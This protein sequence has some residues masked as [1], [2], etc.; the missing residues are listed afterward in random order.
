[1][2]VAESSKQK[3][4][5]EK[6]QGL[7][8]LL[9]PLE[10]ATH[11]RNQSTSPPQVSYL[12]S[13]RREVIKKIVTWADSHL[14]NSHICWL[15]GSKGS[16]KSSIAQE[17][18]ESFEKKKRLAGSYFWSQHSAEDRR[19][20]TQLSGTLAFQLASSV[21]KTAPL[22]EAALVEEPGL[23]DPF[24]SIPTQLQ[25]LVY[26]PIAKTAKPGFTTMALKG[27]HLLVLDGIDECQDKERLLDFLD[28]AGK[29][30]TDNPTVPLRILITG[31]IDSHFALRAD[32]N[33][34]HRIDLAQYT[35]K[36]DVG[37]YIQA[38][39]TKHYEAAKQTG[40][41]PTN[42]PS[43]ADIRTLDDIAN[44]SFPTASALIKF[45]LRHGSENSTAI[46]PLPLTDARLDAFY[47]EIFVQAQELPHSANIISAIALLKTPVSVS[48]LAKLLGTYNY[49]VMDVLSRISGLVDV[50]GTD[51]LP[52][53]FSLPGVRD[54]LLDET[55][56]Q[57][58]HVDLAV[59]RSSAFSSLDTAIAYYD[60]L[61]EDKWMMP[62]LPDH[63]Q[64][65]IVQWPQHLDLIMESD[66]S[67]DIGGFESRWAVILSRIQFLPQFS[68]V[69]AILAL[70]KEPIPI[71]NLLAILQSEMSDISLILYGLTPIVRRGSRTSTALELS[72]R[73]S[74]RHKAVAEFLLD[75]AR[76]HPHGLSIAPSEFTFLS[77]RYLDIVFGLPISFMNDKS[78][79]P[80][81]PIFLALAVEQ[82]P[83][84]DL[85]SLDE[86]YNPVKAQQVAQVDSMQGW[87]DALTIILEEDEVDLFALNVE[88]AAQ[89]IVAKIPS[90]FDDI[91]ESYLVAAEQQKGQ[92]IAS[93][94]PVSIIEILQGF[95]ILL[96]H[97][98]DSTRLCLQRGRKTGIQ[99]ERYIKV[100]GANRF[101]LSLYRPFSPQQP[102]R[103]HTSP[104]S[105]PLRD[106]RRP[107]SEM[108]R[109]SS[110]PQ[111]PVPVP[112][113]PQTPGQ[114]QYTPAPESPIPIPATPAQ[115]ATQTQDTP[116]PTKKKSSLLRPLR[117]IIFKTSKSTGAKA[118]QAPLP[119]TSQNIGTS[120]SQT[121]V[122]IPA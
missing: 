27:T 83:S 15:Y 114:G 118:P 34:I 24:V 37:A 11:H 105:T 100:S 47:T 72:D 20:S 99:I 42:W 73:V 109:S 84:F 10:S 44:T 50:P 75:G 33:L 49:V 16:G 48:A 19:K 81:W 43:S 8:D 92:V 22:I 53:S 91:E 54:F 122:L 18:A 70:A 76:A 59:L 23:L 45:V 29:Y 9:K 78:F 57:S 35:Y 56:S 39:F 2:V 62:L 104:P 69:I 103:S 17:I 120:G 94:S 96:A 97:K 86:P 102:R 51:E 64:D 30:F 58:L 89:A 25:R 82:D 113:T 41:E 4:K 101:F 60:G 107:M 31:R 12:P 32:S 66:S 68:T 63:I 106:P 95:R 93:R 77:Q 7:K 112:R 116:T 65:A 88:K 79:L 40:T 28:H 38:S 14:I 3:A 13:T 87:K 98:G 90:A 1:M 110:M 85:D 71:V 55:R 36:E 52:L 67:F 5:S 46:E 117:S 26:D 21:P 115:A 61:S 80:T 111:S 119:S 6:A 121:G 108:V 74:F